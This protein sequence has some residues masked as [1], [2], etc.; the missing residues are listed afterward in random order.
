MVNE[1]KKGIYLLLVIILLSGCSLGNTPTSK[2]EEYL[3]KYQR[4]DK[5]I[6]IDPLDLSVESNL[7]EKQK[8]EYV[9]LIK[10]QYSNLEYEI[11]EEEIDGKT[12]IVETSVSVYDYHSALT[13]KD[14]SLR[15][16]TLKKQKKRTTYT[17]DFELEKDEKG[18]WNLKEPDQEIKDKLLGIYSK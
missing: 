10:K 5:K 8:K 17:I 3:S 4:L 18:N 9:T 2:V 15:I 11:K 13:K 16:K 14:D 12:A 7:E 6:K 1:M